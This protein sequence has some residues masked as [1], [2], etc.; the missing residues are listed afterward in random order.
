MLTAGS[1]I[2]R[3]HTSRC[4]YVMALPA[5]S[6]EHPSHLAQVC[7]HVLNAPGLQF[8]AVFVLRSRFGRSERNNRW[9]EEAPSHEIAEVDVTNEHAQ[10]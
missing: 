6:E 5:A 7:H 10:R 4:A 1:R 3:P 2:E 9:E 8:V